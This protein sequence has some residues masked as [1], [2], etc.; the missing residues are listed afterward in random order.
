MAG[1]KFTDQ[2]NLKTTCADGDYIFEII[3]FEL[4]LSDKGDDK[5]IVLLQIEK[6]HVKVYDHI[7]LSEKAAWRMDTL[8]K[9]CGVVVAKGAD[10]E[11]DPE[12]RDREGAHF[13]NLVGLRGSARFFK[14]TY[15][16]PSGG[17]KKESM[18]VQTYYTNKEKLVRN[19]NAVA[20]P[21]RKNIE[22]EKPPF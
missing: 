3:G 10:I 8:L 16:P 19:A 11:F 17:S 5:V 4:G 18:K 13:V 14:D 7:T 21:V 2:E 9:C 6:E 22:N 1:Y 15:T 20:Q 12:Q